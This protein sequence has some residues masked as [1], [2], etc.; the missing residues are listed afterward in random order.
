MTDLTRGVHLR[1]TCAAALLS[2]TLHDLRLWWRA[3]GLYSA[4]LEIEILVLALATVSSACL[5]QARALTDILDGL[6]AKR[7]GSLLCH[8]APSACLVED[9]LARQT[10][11]PNLL[12][13]ASE[14]THLMTPIELEVRHLCE[15]LETD[16]AIARCLAVKIC[17]DRGTG[18][19]STRAAGP[20]PALQELQ[21]A[22]D[23]LEEKQQPSKARQ[24]TQDS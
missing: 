23:E 3:A 15:A 11:G 8:P 17:A 5:A 4:T 6:P 2:L 22:E 12:S 24:E 1:S 21:L 10:Q 19:R 13:E 9:V 18:T 14:A 16:C 7:T 20:A